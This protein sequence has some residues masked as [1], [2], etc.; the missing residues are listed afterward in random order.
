MIVLDVVFIAVAVKTCKTTC[1]WL[2]QIT[3]SWSDDF[4]ALNENC[5]DVSV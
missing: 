5:V 4:I 2:E 1:L 3:A